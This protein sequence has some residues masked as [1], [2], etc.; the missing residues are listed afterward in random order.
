MSFSSIKDTTH[1]SQS[2]KL[3]DMSESPVIG[4][5]RKAGSPSND[6]THI[7]QSQESQRK[8]NPEVI[9]LRSPDS[10]KL[11]LSRSH[12]HV[13]H[14][15]QSQESHLAEKPSDASPRGG[16]KLKLSRPNANIT[17]ISQSQLS[18]NEEKPHMEK[19]EEKKVKQSRPDA[20][21]TRVSR[22]Q[23]SQNE[24]KPQR[25]R[26]GE[27]T[28]IS[29]SQNSQVKQSDIVKDCE[30]ASVSPEIHPVEIRV[31]ETPS[32]E[33]TSASKRRKISSP[34]LTH[35]SDTERSMTAE[36]HRFTSVSSPGIQNS[37]SGSAIN[38]SPAV[39]PGERGN[40]V[41]NSP[42]GSTSKGVDDMS[43]LKST[44]SPSGSGWMSKK[45]FSINKEKSQMNMTNYLGA[46][47][48]SG[49]SSSRV[50]FQAGNN[51]KESQV[52]LLKEEE[53]TVREAKKSR[54]SS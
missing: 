28:H 20:N 42:R 48:D 26:M 41:R 24:E 6:I 32:P 39:Q 54:S 53:Q 33:I 17:H 35:I 18:Q 2:E 46:V 14:I 12:A 22:S 37:T 4:Q 30:D 10:R 45:S 47:E 19:T 29:Q 38:T 25:K 50:G 21:I 27:I 40:S 16:K 44:V 8:D 23:L 36:S 15:S 7:S 49:E 43:C 3:E 51:P 5:K 9:L 34:D 52:F 1:I 13:T 31:N 11:S